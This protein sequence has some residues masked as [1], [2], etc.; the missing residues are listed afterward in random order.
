MI[1]NNKK[2][3]QRGDIGYSSTIESTAPVYQ[4]VWVS[5]LILI[6]THNKK[7]YSGL[8]LWLILRSINLTNIKAGEFLYSKLRPSEFGSRNTIKSAIKQMFAL[9]LC[10]KTSSGNYQI[11]PYLKEGL[12]FKFELNFPIRTF[13]FSAL[14]A[15]SVYS[16]RFAPSR[17]KKRYGYYGLSY[18]G[19][20]KLTGYSLSQCQRL[21]KAAKKHHLLKTIRKYNDTGITLMK[22]MNFSDIIDEVRLEPGGAGALV[23]KQK[24]E[25]VIISEKHLEI[26][27]LIQNRMK[28]LG[29]WN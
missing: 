23:K 5:Y 1:K 13:L 10:K 24:G 11:I 9:G 3:K 8:R 20:S 28:V 22:G 15:K 27:P 14:I 12:E 16:Q 18:S 19:M 17:K 29:K 26:I 6:K 25:L 2:Y 7:F 4:S 21:I